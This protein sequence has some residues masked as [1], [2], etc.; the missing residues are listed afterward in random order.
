[1]KKKV[2]GFFAAV[3]LA[4]VGTVLLVAYVN[5]AEERAL[6][7]EEIVEVFVA[8]E[9]I[10]RGTSG[11]TIESSVVVERIPIKVQVANAVADL[12][13]LE[14]LVTEVDVLPGEQLTF[15]RFV[16]QV[17]ESRFQRQIAAPDDLLEVT[18]ALS[19]QRV[20]GGS[21]IPGDR[22]AV[23]ASFDPFDISN[24]ELPEG[25]ELTV[26]TEQLDDVLDSFFEDELLTGDETPSVTHILEHKV[27]VTSVQLEEI[28]EVTAAEEDGPAGLSPTGNLLVTVALDAPTLE[29]LVFTQEFGRIWLAA[30]PDNA[31]ETGTQIIDRSN[32]FGEDE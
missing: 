5:G 28:P 22:V 25:L 6:A 4:I 19:P 9:V 2:A 15:D 7:G 23:V 8:Q 27:L 30:E 12:T 29:R 24:V 21:I 32:V 11:A 14:E 3:L 1:M 26:T 20:V 13:D 18:V 17:D 10:P 31:S 16:E